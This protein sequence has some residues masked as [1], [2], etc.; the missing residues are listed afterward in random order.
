MI[1]TSDF[2]GYIN[3]KKENEKKSS[4]MIAAA[5]KTSPGGK[6]KDEPVEQITEKQGQVKNQEEIEYLNNK[7]SIFD[8]IL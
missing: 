2:L 5:L 1:V 3:R 8:A 6:E 4:P 7:T